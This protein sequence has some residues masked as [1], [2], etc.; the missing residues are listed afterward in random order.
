MVF[1][2]TKGGKSKGGGGRKE[3]GHEHDG[4]WLSHYQ[5]YFDAV[6]KLYFAV[7][8]FPTVTDSTAPPPPLSK[9]KGGRA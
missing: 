5:T 2:W 6:S 1:S 9:R 4:N 8:S 7:E 3:R